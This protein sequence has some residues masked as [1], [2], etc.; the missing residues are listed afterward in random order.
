M[1]ESQKIKISRDE[2]NIRVCHDDLLLFEGTGD[3]NDEKWEVDFAKESG[4]QSDFR[5]AGAKEEDFK[6]T[7]S[8]RLSIGNLTFSDAR[9]EARPSGVVVEVPAAEG[10]PGSLRLTS[11]DK[12][13]TWDGEL[14]FDEPLSCRLIEPQRLQAALYFDRSEPD[15][16]PRCFATVKLDQFTME[17]R[18]SDRLQ[19]GTV[20]N[21]SGL[22]GLL[23][24]GI[25]ENLR[26]ELEHAEKEFNELKPR[27][28]DLLDDAPPG[29]SEGPSNVEN[30]AAA[31]IIRGYL[32]LLVRDF[33]DRR[34]GY[35]TP[36]FDR[37]IDAIRRG[38]LNPGL[39]D[40]IIN[41]EL[42]SLARY[43]PRPLPR[44]ADLQ[45]LE[46]ELQ[47][48]RGYLHW[49]PIFNAASSTLSDFETGQTPDN[50]V[51]PTT[52]FENIAYRI[53]ACKDLLQAIDAALGSS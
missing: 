34:P 52:V 53:L 31:T 39:L 5:L 20:E 22:R 38:Y 18:L 32:P 50:P 14:A 15:A 48:R 40:A 51:E 45:A 36:R 19:E 2:G 29:T 4:L 46:A 17:L 25:A 6:L 44:L 10:D 11:G 43:I 37:E 8:G 26:A 3:D 13:G 12:P 7:G 21:L 42:F 30:S 49:P 9:V 23:L 33:F 1:T 41:P 24:T 47:I 27:L 28:F 16:P 35:L